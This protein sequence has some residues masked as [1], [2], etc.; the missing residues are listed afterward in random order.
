MLFALA[1]GGSRLRLRQFPGAMADPKKHPEAV[2][3][4]ARP[5]SSC[6]TRPP[7]PAGKPL[8]V[9]SSKAACDE[10]GIECIIQNAEGDKDNMAT[11]AD[12]MIADGIGC[13]LHCQP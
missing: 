6:P 9:H 2:K 13:A 12:Q 5:V 3:A 11:I 7:R 10:A 1:T 8:T 4:A